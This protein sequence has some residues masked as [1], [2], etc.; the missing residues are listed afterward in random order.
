MPL[1]FASTIVTNPA[2]TL[3]A[4]GLTYL[5]GQVTSY[6]Q[7]R[8]RCYTSPEQLDRVTF[9]LVAGMSLDNVSELSHV[10]CDAVELFIRWTR[11]ITS[12]ATESGR[13]IDRIASWRSGLAL[14]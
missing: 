2:R 14:G 10:D 11:I 5:S 1:K 8:L 7:L 13:L 6:G 12:L 9:D 4:R 3:G